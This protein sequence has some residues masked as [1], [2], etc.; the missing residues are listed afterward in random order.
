MNCLMNPGLIP[1]SVSQRMSKVC[2]NKYDQAKYQNAAAVLH[3]VWALPVN[4]L[5]N[6]AGVVVQT[7][8]TLVALVAAGVFKLL[9]CFNREWNT[10]ARKC[11]FAAKEISE[12]PTM[13][14]RILYPA[15]KY[16]ETKHYLETYEYTH[17]EQMGDEALRFSEFN[18][19]ENVWDLYG[20]QAPYQV[21]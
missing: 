7:V 10:T 17:N 16:R 5:V 3:F 11:L 9:S 4:T 13:L 8:I 14:I 12:V 19:E 6:A 1:I 2:R 18:D 20:Q 15:F 21:L